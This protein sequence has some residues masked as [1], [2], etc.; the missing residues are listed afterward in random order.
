MLEALLKIIDRLIELKRGR[1]LGRKEIFDRVIEPTFNELVLVHG[2]YIKMFED[3]RVYTASWSGLASELT[4]RAE[5]AKSELRSRRSE[6]EP[7]RQKIRAFAT[8]LASSQLPNE[9]KGFV[10]AVIRYFPSGEPSLPQSSAT[11]VLGYLD[12]DLKPEDLDTLVSKT[13]QRHRNAWSDV[14]TAFAK[15]KIAVAS[16]R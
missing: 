5:K 13:I 11:T 15:L 10:D 6:F 3:L 16:A 1:I 7:I 9:E 2:D 8:G 12:Q 4:G 14:T